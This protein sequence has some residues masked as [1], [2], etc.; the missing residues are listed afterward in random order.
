MKRAVVC[1]G[2]GAWHPRGVARL[3][4][5]LSDVGEAAEPA[6]WTEHPAGCPAHQDL[7]Y[8]FKPW[9]MNYAM[10]MGFDQAIWVDASCWAIR[11]LWPL[12]QKITDDGYLL[13]LG[14]WTAGEWCTDAALEPLGVTR[15]QALTIPAIH[16]GA[17]GLDFRNRMAREFLSEWMRL[18]LDGVTFPGPWSNKNNEASADPRVLGHR[19]DQTAASVLAA[20]YGWTLTHCPW[21]FAFWTET[22]HAETIIVARGM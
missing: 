20:R 13:F 10:D 15:E 11:P 18:S 17:I 7:P 2:V 22:P 6:T 19:H 9:A 8:A 5:S 21:G 3:V 4:K 14:G 12:W 16:A 1:Y